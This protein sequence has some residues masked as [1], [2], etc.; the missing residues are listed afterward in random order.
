MQ[1]Q[2]PG[3]NAYLQLSLNHFPL[4][5]DQ[6][7]FGNGAYDVPMNL[8]TATSA[9][10]QISAHGNDIQHQRDVDL[11]APPGPVI[12]NQV[13]PHI[14]NALAP[15]NSVEA[16]RSKKRSKPCS[17]CQAAKK[18]RRPPDWIVFVTDLYLVP[19]Y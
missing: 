11:K 7:L 9:Q 18:S 16:P 5:I 19:P 3:L 12:T 8:P 1:L 15:T 14:I 10:L 13:Q 4:D 6:S 17:A 2:D